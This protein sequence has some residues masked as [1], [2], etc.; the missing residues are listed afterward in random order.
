MISVK[1][2]EYVGGTWQYAVDIDGKTHKIG[3][4]SDYNSAARM[5]K[6]GVKSAKRFLETGQVAR[7]PKKYEK[8]S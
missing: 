4:G 3:T 5:A 7:L 2:Y 6:S 8:T 1:L